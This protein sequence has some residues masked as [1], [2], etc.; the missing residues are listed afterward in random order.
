MSLLN[1]TR[2]NE[3][4]MNFLTKDFMELEGYIHR[5]KPTSEINNSIH[6]HFTKKAESIDF[7]L[8]HRIYIERKKLGFGDRAF[9]FMWYL[10]LKNLFQNNN[11]PKLLEIGVYKGQVISLWS[12]ISKELRGNAQI[13]CISPLTGN[14]VPKRNITFYIQYLLSKEFRLQIA[15]GNFYDNEEYLEIIKSVFQNFALDFSKVEFHKGLSSDELIVSAL[16]DSKFDLVYID[17]DH[18]RKGVEMD[19]Q[20]YATKIVTNGF[21]VMDDASCNLPGGEN[22]EYWKGYQSVSDACNMLPSLGFENV[23]NV[24]HNRIFQKNR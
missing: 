24:G 3:S 18:T 2:Q 6:R 9:H 19:I 14:P 12:L 13:S 20:N 8:N 15:S 11:S 10:L 4:L 21:L 17:G 23:L 1:L 16:K 22:N 5:Y 7:L